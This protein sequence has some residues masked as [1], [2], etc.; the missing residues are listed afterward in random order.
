MQLEPILGWNAIPAVFVA[1]FMFL[2][3][4][5]PS[6]SR[7]RALRDLQGFLEIGQAIESPFGAHRYISAPGQRLHRAQATTATT[8][9]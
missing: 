4:L 1:A 5:Y 7:R 2:V 8:S 6:P 9:T 3:S